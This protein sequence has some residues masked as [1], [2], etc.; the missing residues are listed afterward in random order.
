MPPPTLCRWGVVWP[1]H[2][3]QATR[4]HFLL[5]PSGPMGR[6]EPAKKS[7]DGGGVCSGQTSPHR[8]EPGGGVRSVSGPLLRILVPA[9]IILPLALRDG[10]AG[11]SWSTS[12]RI[13]SLDSRPPSPFSPPVLEKRPGVRGTDGGT[14]KPTFAPHLRLLHKSRRRAAAERRCAAR[15]SVADRAR[16]WYT[17]QVGRGAKFPLAGVGICGA[18]ELSRSES[19]IGLVGRLLANKP[20]RFQLPTAEGRHLFGRTDTPAA[21]ILP[22][23]KTAF[24]GKNCATGGRCSSGRELS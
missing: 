7:A 12:R 16:R 20:R 15:A 19:A 2:A 8:D 11:Q 3:A 14:P 6:T 24:K 5:V 18:T 17:S 10:K 1:P 13:S 4:L 23:A 9:P 22:P 21:D